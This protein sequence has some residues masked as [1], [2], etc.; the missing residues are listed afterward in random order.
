MQYA[1][2]CMPAARQY[3][4]LHGVTFNMNVE[5]SLLHGSA[6]EMFPGMTIF[7]NY[8]MLRQ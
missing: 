2:V 5:A 6:S 4:T 3:Q 1:Q 8:W 7:R